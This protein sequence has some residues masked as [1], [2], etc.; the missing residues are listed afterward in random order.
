MR[1]KEGHKRKQ[2]ARPTTTQ[3]RFWSLEIDLKVNV[4]SWRILTSKLG[5]ALILSWCYHDFIVALPLFFH[6]V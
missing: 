2:L 6:D 3:A 1:K 5:V 4:T